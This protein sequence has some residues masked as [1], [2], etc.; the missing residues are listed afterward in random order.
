MLGHILT[1]LDAKSYM[2]RLAW[3]LLFI[4]LVC[5]SATSEKLGWAEDRSIYPLCGGH[6]TD[7]FL[8]LAPNRDYQLRE[9]NVSA[10]Y[11]SIKQDGT[12]ELKGDVSIWQRQRLITADQATIKR[13]HKSGR[14]S[15]IQLS[16]GVELREPGKMLLTDK[17]DLYLLKKTVEMHQATYRISLSD[18]ESAKLG[19]AELYGINAWGRAD[20]IAISGKG[21]LTL[22]NPTYST[23]SPSSVTWE[24]R[25]KSIKLDKATGSGTAKGAALYL[26]NVP[27]LY[28]PYFTFPINDRRKSGFLFPTFGA[29]SDSGL[30][31]FFPFYWNIAPNY[32]AMISPRL[33]SKRGVMWNG[34][35]RYLT[36][37]HHGYLEAHLLPDDD[38]FSNFQMSQA[39][40]SPGN[41]LL[42]ELLTEGN[43][44]THI[45]LEHTSQFDDHWSS[46]LFFDYVSDDYYFI[47]FSKDLASSTQNQLLRQGDLQ[48]LGKHWEFLTRV[49]N[50]QTL[51]PLNQSDIKNQYSRLPQFELNGYYPMGSM[52]PSY[53]L[54]SELVYFTID[55]DPVTG[56]SLPDGYRIHVAP[57]A[58]YPIIKSHGFIIPGVT[59][60]TSYYALTNQL[61]GRESHISRSLPIVD[62]DA[63]LIL[64]RDTQVFSSPFTQ[65]L[66][67]RVYY[68]FVPF[69][70]QKDIPLFDTALNIFSFDQLFRNNR[71]NGIDRIGDANQVSLALTSRLLDPRSGE[72]VFRASVG[73][74]IYFRD[75]KVTLCNTLGC[76]DDLTAVGAIPPGEAT[77]PIVA[78]LAYHLDLDWSL[79][80]GF[81][82]D[83]YN[84]QSNNA[85][86]DLHYQPR[87]NKIFNFRYD[88]IRNGD[89][90]NPVETP[91]SSTRRN[92]SQT[93]TSFVWPLN[94]RWSS[95]GNWSYNVSH[96]HLQTYF[97]GLQYESC[98]W[99]I[100]A[101]GGRSFRTLNPE[102][103]KE[104]DN[105]IYLQFHLKGLG[106]LGSSDPKK[107]L[108]NHINGY[109][110]TF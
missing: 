57:R 81:A 24:L 35:F 88:F 36:Q 2:Q 101:I 73:Q 110:D 103:S 98:C 8:P 30:D 55:D 39:T 79:Y 70:N 65:T 97:V 40:S 12:S 27:I 3:L 37:K 1:K 58:T 63:G 43:D 11:A 61:P 78:A 59:L 104:F 56:D 60:D 46:N 71:F 31:V 69:D 106:N 17:M 85:N 94:K 52:E 74:I 21:I 50:Y 45:K 48:Y 42:T 10:T 84:Q 18:T 62:I 77:S 29:S 54:N 9:L 102:G 16:G 19:I 33:L 7:P 89:I 51:H 14:I 32:D 34:H 93:T 26:K 41:P 6:F 82:W 25:A 22:Q 86:V 15:H 72:E 49:Q 5:L 38:E 107:I 91:G 105:L 96:G 23:C 67:P 109:H 87:N 53:Y 75:R 90:I 99:A 76:V 68:L 95:L 64:Q 100:R 28:A 44:R 20:Q 92:L 4:P 66:E 83:P 47:D 80:T 13:S 108:E